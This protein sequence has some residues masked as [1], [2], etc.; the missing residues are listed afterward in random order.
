MLIIH[1]K[2]LFLQI[3]L[4]MKPC[5]GFDQFSGNISTALGSVMNPCYAIY[6][7]GIKTHMPLNLI[8]MRPSKL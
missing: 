7:Q 2:R 3:H 8:C 6:G 4:I 5:P 1:V